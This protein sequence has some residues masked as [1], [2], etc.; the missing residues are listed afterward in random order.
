M[1]FFFFLAHTHKPKCEQ[2]YT[3]KVNNGKKSKLYFIINRL[4]IVSSEYKL[5]VC[6]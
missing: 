3:Q 5:S 1:F 2:Q 6:A 4:I